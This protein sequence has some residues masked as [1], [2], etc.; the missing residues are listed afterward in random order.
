MPLNKETKP[1]L[2]YKSNVK[3]ISDFPTCIYTFACFYL[4]INPEEE[5]EKIIN[6]GR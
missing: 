1:Y 3:T 6:S 4:F 2:R 5:E